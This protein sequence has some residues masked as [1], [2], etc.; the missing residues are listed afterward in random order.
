MTGAARSPW[1]RWLTTFGRVVAM[2]WSGAVALLVGGIVLVTVRGAS[3]HVVESPS[4]APSI[5]VGALAVMEPTS[6]AEADRL[7]VG[8]VIAF[9]HPEIDQLVLHRI[10][11][12]RVVDGV[13][14]FQTKGDANAAP[15]GR[16]VASEEV[17]SRLGR[18][19]PGLGTVLLWLRP[20]FGLLLLVGVPLLVIGASRLGG[21][22]AEVANA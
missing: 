20:P 21:R 13:T 18:S 16:L 14:Y 8:E 22:S 7:Q 10:I 2:T 12:V 17:H 19:I 6:E 15:D 11:D 1:P 3:I 9:S 5:P 4:M